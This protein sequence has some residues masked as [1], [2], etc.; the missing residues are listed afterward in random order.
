MDYEG[1]FIAINQKNLKKINHGMSA[2][3]SPR[4]RPYHKSPEALLA[5]L[6]KYF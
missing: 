5:G 4:P 2:M 3:G 1:L 6:D